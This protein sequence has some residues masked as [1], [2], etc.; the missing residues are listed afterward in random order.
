VLGRDSLKG[1]GCVGADGGVGVCLSFLQGGDGSFGYGTQLQECED[2]FATHLEVGVVDCPGQRVN[3]RRVGWADVAQDAHGLLSPGRIGPL[4]HVDP[5]AHG[6]IV[7][8][9]WR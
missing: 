1:A 6:L 8:H 5:V 3:R 2:R 9:R 7:R 4:Q